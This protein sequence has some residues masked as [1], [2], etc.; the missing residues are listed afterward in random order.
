MTENLQRLAQEGVLF[1]ECFCGGPTCSA[2]RAALLTGMSPHSSG[3]I[4]LAHRGFALKDVKQHIVHTLRG[5][6]YSSTLIGVQHV[7]NWANNGA[8]G[9]GY[10]NVVQL[11]NLW[12][13][14]QIAAAAE[15]FFQAPPAEPFFL[16]VGFVHTHRE[17]PEP[18]PA[19]DARYC[20]PPA[21]LPDTPETRCDMARYKASARILDDGMGKVLAALA[22]SGPAENTLVICTTDHGI[23][24][25]GMKCNL[26]DHG[27]GVMLI[28]RGPGGFDGGKV[29]DSLISQVDV[30][31]T[32]CDLLGIDP[33][34]WLEG[35]SFMPVIRGE[36]DE[37]N[38]AVFCEVTYHAAYE[39]MRAVRTKRWNYIRR[40]DDRGRPNLPNC[41]DSPSKDVWLANGWRDR[42]LAREEF[43][44]V[45]FDP[46]E[47]R[48]LAGDP[49]AAEPLAADE[50][51]PQRPAIRSSCEGG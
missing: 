41:D 39:P 29:V 7:V 47:T 26:T 34:E 16:T 12:N 9:I 32:L 18:G 5:A 14:G 13:H 8:D 15:Q 28:V 25:P 19:E 46:N 42:A 22:E 30:F 11:K 50:P 40:F 27:T 10:D 37:V 51:Q 3:M 48:N 36:A 38:E 33:P 2:S 45:V 1:R 49:A 20:R 43:Y 21:P 17:F 4:G 44:D 35:R 23:A 6:G 31:P 24:F